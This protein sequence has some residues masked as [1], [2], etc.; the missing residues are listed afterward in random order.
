M[1]FRLALAL[2]AL[3][4]CAAA[5][6]AH[7]DRRSFTRTYEYTTMPEGQTELEIYST[8]SVSRFTD[9]APRAFELQLEIEHGITDRFDLGLYHVFT[10]VSAADAMA[11][12]PLQFSALK[13]RG[14]Y[15]FAERGE[16]PVDSL[17]YLEVAK[18]F[19]EGV[20]E[21]EGKAI[22]A[23]DFAQLVVAANLIA[24]MEF[25]PDAPETE[26]ELGWAVGAAYEVVPALRLGVE[27]YGGFEAAEPEELSASVGPTLSWGSSGKLW[28]AGTLGFGVTD[29]AS[30]FSGRMI[31]GIDL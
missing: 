21:L 30:R 3:G 13:L 25:G 1:K 17:A 27:T 24:E 22:L 5:P 31:L 10:Q 8:Q 20:Y 12:Q 7:A 9:G 19:G 16:L 23:R 18:D 15:R 6:F 14:R 4:L 2:G 26:V 11:A 28:V 29:E